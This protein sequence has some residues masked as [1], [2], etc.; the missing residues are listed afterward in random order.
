MIDS[1]MSAFRLPCTERNFLYFSLIF[2]FVFSYIFTNFNSHPLINDEAIE[3]LVAEDIPVNHFEFF[4]PPYRTGI[5]TEIESLLPYL[6]HFLQSI[7]G[8]DLRAVRFV[9]AFCIGFGACFYYLLLKNHFSEAYGIWGLFLLFCS[10][11]LGYYSRILTRNGI[12]SLW[13]CMILYLLWKYLD[14]ARSGRSK[15]WIMLVLPFAIVCS[16]LSY[17]SFKFF[18][19]ATYLAL[20]FWS[21]FY[22]NRKREILLISL[23]MI[24]A[25]GVMMFLIIKGHSSLKMLL[26]RGNYVLVGGKSA[27]ILLDNILCSFLMPFYFKSDGAFLVDMTHI[28]F[29]RHAL[30]YFL[31]PFYLIGL[32]SIFRKR[33]PE[34]EFHRVLFI[35]LIITTALLGVGGPVLKHHYVSFPLIIFFSVLGYKTVVERAISIVSVSAI[36]KISLAFLAIYLSSEMIHLTWVIPEDE[37]LVHETKVPVVMSTEAI[38]DSERFEKVYVIEGV[39]RDTLQYYVRS[40]P[41]IVTIRPGGNEAALVNEDLKK[42]ISVCIVMDGRKTPPVVS[43]VLGFP[44]CFTRSEKVIDMWEITAFELKNDC[45]G[46]ISGEDTREALEKQQL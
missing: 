11:Y 18:S 2:L 17:T 7:F 40:N 30:S 35:I 22:A 15:T 41:K 5:V 10:A 25:A 33:T 34:V 42:G 26:F 44:E 14:A 29:H 45:L 16:N 12:S 32:A 8:R 20:L 19:I 43:S 27:G 9:F 39:A 6:I 3:L 37:G 36:Q 46:R 38:E 31:C 4:A 28:T 1:K 23:N 21:V 13:V 24:L